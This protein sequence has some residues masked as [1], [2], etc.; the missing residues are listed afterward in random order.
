MSVEWGGV[1]PF[2][3]AVL[4]AVILI[5]VI[6]GNFAL[7]VADSWFRIPDSYRQPL[8][9]ASVLASAAVA[10]LFAAAALLLYKQIREKD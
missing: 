1:G 3:F 9:Q 8:S 2:T 10:V 7:S 4:A 6:V 5:V